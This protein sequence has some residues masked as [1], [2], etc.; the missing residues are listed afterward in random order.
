MTIY[1]C[2]PT[3]DT[4]KRC[5]DAGITRVLFPVPS[6]GDDAV[7]GILDTYAKLAG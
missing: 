6:L 4:V 1:F 3:E 7:Q 2:P 5:A